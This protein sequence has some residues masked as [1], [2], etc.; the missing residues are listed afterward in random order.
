LVVFGSPIRVS[1]LHSASGPGLATEP[2]SFIRLNGAEV[3]VVAIDADRRGRVL[4]VDRTA[5]GGAVMVT[6]E[7]VLI[8]L[9]AEGDELDAIVAGLGPEGWST[10]T[11]AP[12]WTIAHQIAH[13]AWTD[14]AA[15][16][17]LTDPD[18]FADLQRAAA[19]D[20]TA[21]VEA[22][23]RQGAEGTP[24][25]LL[26]RWRDGR[27]RLRARLGEAAGRV[28]WIG[29][30]MSPAS[31]ASA[32]IMETWA[33][34]T[35]VADALG[36]ERAPTARLRHVAHLGV[37][38]RDFAYAVHG[39]PAPPEPFRVE[40]TAPDGTTW[41]WGPDGH[42][43]DVAGPALDFCLLVTRRRNRADLRLTAAERAEQWLQI[44]QAFAGPPGPGRAPGAPR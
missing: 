24:A 44:A 40:L 31:M 34:G 16:L 36:V 26:D 21:V 3:D 25:E 15:L 6:A 43:A 5:A 20:L 29:T 13:L 11:P 30:T 7:Q 18:A 8:D 4:G 41:A 17:A 1:R 22:G 32:R 37:A 38:T 14:D 28:P 12:G 2:I 33:H 35:D 39:R 10:P 27:E 23:A 19:T 9:R 42:P